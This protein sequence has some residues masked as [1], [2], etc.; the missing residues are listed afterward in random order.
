MSSNSFAHRIPGLSVSE[1]KA[2]E[3]EEN[4]SSVRDLAQEIDKLVNR[5]ESHTAV[6]ASAPPLPASLLTGKPSPAIETQPIKT[7]QEQP[8]RSIP[9]SSSS[10]EA[11]FV[12]ATMAIKRESTSAHHATS[13]RTPLTLSASAPPS[14]YT[15]LSLS[16]QSSAVSSL[17]STSQRVSQLSSLRSKPVQDSASI[18]RSTH[19]PVEVPEQE[20]TQIL[21]IDALSLDAGEI[22]SEEYSSIR[23]VPELSS[24]NNAK[25]H[26][27]SSKLLATT[28]PYNHASQ[29]RQGH[30]PQ[31]R[32]RSNAKA[33]VSMVD[34]SSSS[35]PHLASMEN[36]TSSVVNLTKRAGILFA[37]AQ[38]DYQ[39]GQVSAAIMNAKLATLYDPTNMQYQTMLES[40]RRESSQPHTIETESMSSAC[41]SM[42]SDAERAEDEG[43]IDEALH[44]LDKAIHRYPKTP[45]LYNKKGVILAM[46]SHR[47]SEAR[48]ILEEAVRMAPEHPHYRNNLGKVMEK[49]GLGKK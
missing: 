5:V 22:Y 7:F 21:N 26:T 49:L 15:S 4:F 12:E 38:K 32:S 34:L 37:E 48:K 41:A 6:I 27:P 24:A 46:R 29:N 16:E 2:N 9:A 17:Q 28:P 18:P 36:S 35:G 40:W 13:K 23:A 10:S 8:A 25:P 11:S 39:Q 3:F 45:A 47:Y 19:L 1:D 31:E 14:H 30:I 43:N 44:I 20:R 33:S 42:Y